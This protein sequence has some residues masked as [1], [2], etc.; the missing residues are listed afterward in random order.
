MDTG[1]TEKHLYTLAAGIDKERFNVSICY[2]KGGERFIQYGKQELGI[3]LVGLK[4]E[5]IYSIEAFR[6]M[7]KLVKIIRDR[8][9]DIVQ[10]F[11]FK[12]DTYGVLISKLA[13]VSKIISSRRDMGDLKKPR[14]IFLNKLMNRFINRHIMVCDAV[15][16]RFH[17]IEGIPKDK[18]I[19]LYN[20][21]DLARFNPGN[22]PRKSREELG[23]EEGDFVVGTVA[24]FRPE[25]AYHIFFEGIKK[26]RHSIGNLKVITLG[27]GSTREYFEAY[28]RENDLNGL[29]RFIGHVEDV[30]NYLPF[31][32]VFCMVPN[33][34][35]GFSNSILEAMAMGKPVIATDVGGNKES[36]AHNETGF[37]IPPDNSELLAEFI[38]KLHAD[39]E[40]RLNMGKKARKRAEE[41]F[42]LELMISGH[43]DLYEGILR[44]TANC[45]SREFNNT[46]LREQQK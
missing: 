15:G 37:I 36:V 40:M 1:G 28:C 18:M 2:F 35:E 29:V 31:M 26:I 42:P 24:H 43:E 44:Q 34:N 8:K 12:S 33:K 16:N 7:F 25:K 45:N 13:G 41:V 32:D 10:T 22:K 3:D 17:E 5:R 38:L 19:T 27:G 30:E 4:L 21:V 6:Q 9:I 20:G 11:H 46:P 23:I 14:Q 39:P